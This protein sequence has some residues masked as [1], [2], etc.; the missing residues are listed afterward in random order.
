MPG[1]VET[2]GRPRHSLRLYF[3]LAR[4][5]EPRCEECPSRDKDGFPIPPRKG[6][7]FRAL[8]VKWQQYMKEDTFTVVLRCRQHIPEGSWVEGEDKPTKEADPEGDK[9]YAYIVRKFRLDMGDA[10]RHRR[11]RP[12]GNDLP[13]GSGAHEGTPRSVVPRR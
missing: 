1:G 9:H 3:H 10:D 8:R 13:R 2:P 6:E 12:E 7:V 5:G 4:L 11:A